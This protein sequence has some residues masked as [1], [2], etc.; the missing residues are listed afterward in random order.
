MSGA[1]EAEWLP[2]AVAAASAGDAAAFTRLV[3][4]HDDDLVRVAYLVTND[5]DLAREAAQAAW[6]IAWRKLST[7]RD[8]EHVRAWLV[9]IS[10]NEAR[11]LL[12]RRRRTAIREIPVDSFDEG[13]LGRSTGHGSGPDDR[14]LDLAAA[15]RTLSPD[16][17]AIVAMRYAM[18]LTSDE[19]GR[20]VGLSAAGVR[21]RLAR[22]LARLRKELR[23]D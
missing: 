4:F 12:R 7:V 9:A 16:D 10:V 20:S 19:I 13:V 3:A 6:A 21:S 5:V 1:I 17:R 14:S 2:D 15:M 8:P 23:D 22:S 18:G 11:Q